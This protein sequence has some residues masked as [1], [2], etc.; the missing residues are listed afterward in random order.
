[1]ESMTDKKKTSSGSPAGKGQAWDQ[2]EDYSRI[3]GTA[4]KPYWSAA[5]A[6]PVISLDG[7]WEVKHKDSLEKEIG[8][9]IQTGWRQ[10][11]IPSDMNAHRDSDFTG[12]Y[13]YRRL[14]EVPKLVRGSHI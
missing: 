10:I 14:I 11:D 7:P 9:V 6:V 1:M 12:K 4:V 3:P 2:A 13:V 5:A 8:S